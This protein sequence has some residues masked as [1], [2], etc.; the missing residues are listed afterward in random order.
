M[1]PTAHISC[2]NDPQDSEGTTLQITPCDKG[3]RPAKP[4]K[5]HTWKVGAEMQEPLSPL[6]W[7]V[8]PPSTSTCHQPGSSLRFSQSSISRHFDEAV[9]DQLSPHITTWL[10]PGHQPVLC[11]EGPLPQSHRICLNIDV[12]KESLQT[13]H[14]TCISQETTRC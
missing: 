12:R 5:G 9:V 13:T 1:N 7:G 8:P 3:H 14:D 11:H 10:A 4:N 2:D 6:G